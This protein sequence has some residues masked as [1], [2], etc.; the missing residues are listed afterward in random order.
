M[1]ERFAL[2]T[3]SKELWERWD[4]FTVPGFH[5]FAISTALLWS[6]WRYALARRISR[7]TL[8]SASIQLRFHS[9]EQLGSTAVLVASP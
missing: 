3:S 4:S 9:S 2:S 7:P 1:W 6:V 5:S 8:M